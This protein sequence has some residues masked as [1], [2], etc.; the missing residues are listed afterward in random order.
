MSD[1]EKLGRL[2]DL[3]RLM[4]DLRLLELEK[5]TRARQDSLDHLAELNRPQPPADDNPIVDG[6]VSLRYQGW[7][8]HRRSAINLVLAQQTAA[9]EEARRNA[10]LAFGRGAVIDKLRNKTRR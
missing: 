9:W 2:N 6:E 4:L 3:A 5:A 8:D 10:A 7:A 1:S